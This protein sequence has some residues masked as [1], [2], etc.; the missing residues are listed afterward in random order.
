MDRFSQAMARHFNVFADC[1]GDEL[2]SERRAFYEQLI[3]AAPRLHNGIA[4]PRSRSGMVTPCVELRTAAA[5][6]R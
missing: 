5:C 3:A 2:S 6:K 1:L 4:T